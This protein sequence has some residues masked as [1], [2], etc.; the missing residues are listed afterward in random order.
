MDYVFSYTNKLKTIGSSHTHYQGQVT[1]ERVYDDQII[2]DTFVTDGPYA[3]AEDAEGRCY[4]WYRIRDHYRYQDKSTPKVERLEVE[5]AD[6]QD[7]MIDTI[8]EQT[9]EE[10]DI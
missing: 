3:S 5:F 7:M 1:I 6:L 4:D 10:L 2:I 8:Y 9:L